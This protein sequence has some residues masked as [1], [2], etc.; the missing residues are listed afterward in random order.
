[1]HTKLL[2]N[3]VLGISGNSRGYQKVNQQA[4]N[5]AHERQTEG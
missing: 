2:T 5:L 4:V 3:A 1:M